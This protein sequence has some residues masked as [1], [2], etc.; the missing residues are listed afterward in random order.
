MG[1]C[2]LVKDM[3]IACL[4]ITHLGVKY[5]I[6]RSPDLV[7]KQIILYKYDS[8]NKLQFR[9]T[10]SANSV[11][12]DTSHQIKGVRAGMP[13]SKAVSIS[14]NSI[15]LRADTE[16]YGKIF[17]RI[18]ADV[19]KIAPK[20][21]QDDLGVA[22][23][24]IKGLKNVYADET[25]IISR[26]LRSVPEFLNPRVGISRSKFFSYVAAISSRQGRATKV[27]GDSKSVSRF[28]R[29]FSVDILPVNWETIRGLHR[30]SIHTIGDLSLQKLGSIQ[31]RFGK[32]GRKAWDLSQGIDLDPIVADKKN[33][34]LTEFISLPFPSISREV[35]FS[36]V[37]SLIRRT[38]TR[39]EIKGKYIVKLTLKCTIFNSPSWSRSIVFKEPAGN[40][41]QASSSVRHILSNVD[42]PGP[43]EDVALT[44]DKLI[45]DH[46]VQSNA[47]SD[48]SN[49]PSGS[50]MTNDVR[51]HVKSDVMKSLYRVVDLDS[52]H[53]LPEM[54]SLQI[55]LDPKSGDS[56]RNLNVP[57][58]IKVKEVKGNPIEIS[59][60]GRRKSPV[61][62]RTLDMW[63]I[64][65]WWM[66]NPIQ[67]IYY[68]VKPDGIGQ[69]TVFKDISQNSYAR[70]CDEEVNNSVNIPWYQQN[71]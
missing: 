61:K 5:E 31:A 60:F 38:Y 57:K 58:K 48:F 26:I 14:P 32:M 1:F 53:P 41:P 35:L 66:P 45:G 56:V 42:L 64:D 22:Y 28:L 29:P 36:A 37:D 17:A 16:I 46:G 3:K 9:R 24:D 30:L 40:A 69:I 54:R 49:N 44:V 21:Q 25:E 6:H 8:S 23:V 13:L 20:I 10:R 63:K 71:Y 65:L 2:I 19:S 51:F 15:V 7:D 12:F 50:F 68:V 67:R 27:G 39:S 55:S 34:E 11:V 43:I 18:M 33:L 47:F 4:L 62:V 52:D 70:S 59:F